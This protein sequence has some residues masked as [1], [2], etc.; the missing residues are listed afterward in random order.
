MEDSTWDPSGYPITFI[1]SADRIPLLADALARA[2]RVAVDTE[3]HSA[4]TFDDGLWSA[5]R[6]VA[7]ALKHTDGSYEAF[8]VDVRDVPTSALA[9]VLGKIE[10]ADAWNANFDDRVLELAGC[11]ITSWRDAMFTDGLLHSGAA[12]FEFWHGLAF[13]AKKYLGIELAG[14]GTTQTSYDGESDLSEEQVRYPGCDALVTLRVAEIL[15]ERVAKHGLA[16][17]VALEQ[18]ARPFILEM[19]KRGLPFDMEGWRREVLEEH[20][21]GKADALRQLADLTGGSEI[22]LFGES[23]T[24]SWNPDSDPQAREALNKWAAAAVKEFTGGQLL[25]KTDKL[26]KIVLKQIKHPVA[27]ELLRYRNHSKVLSTYGENLDTFIGA[28]NRIRP[29]YKQGGVVATG[30]LASD[31]PNAQNFS[32]L[33][34]PYFRPLVEVLPDGTEIPRC[35]VY[36]DLSQAELRVL[37]E[38]AGEERMREQF[39]LGGDFHARTAGEM[40]NV[41]MDELKD[42]DPATYGNNRKKAKGVSFGIPYGLGAE[43]LAT[44]LTVA[45]KLETSK[46]EAQEMLKRYAQAFPAVDAWLTA[47]DRFVKE[48]AKNSTGV[49]WELSFHLYEL[50]SA[51]APV[52]KSLKRR[53]GR[54]ASVEEISYEVMPDARLEK[55]LENKLGHE[56]N[57]EEVEAARAAH[58]SDVTW[59]L[60]FDAPVVLRSGGAPWFFESRSLTGRRRLFTVPMDSSPSMKGK[61]EGVIT[62]AVLTVCTSDQERVAALRAEFADATSLDL[63]VGVNRL[64]RRA[65]EKDFQYRNRSWQHRKSER[66]AC[67]KTF[68]GKN[69][70]RKY[71]LL[72]F[73]REHMGAEVVESHLLPMAFE[74]QV[75]SMGNRFRNH[76]IQSLVADVGLQYY[77]DLHARL[78]R[79]RNAFPVQAVHDSI[80]IECDLAEAEELCRE[81]QEALQ[82][83]LA[84]WCPNVPAVADADIRLSLADEDVV[85]FKDIPGLLA[86]LASQA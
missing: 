31:R 6:I 60:G 65:G 61:F 26:D 19:T 9:P 37:A 8:V 34:K 52:A 7:V 23:D 46:E 32:P 14:K 85:S 3:T 49:D 30:R 15:D 69:K 76:P 18:A 21:H 25:E 55:E 39:R 79:Y 86:K 70:R 20:E 62:S 73:V 35:F 53:L 29:R 28:D 16:V 2:E 17:P 36:A 54:P 75:R 5:L 4:T 45:S 42:S 40:F 10:N 58:I 11:P 24:P 77:A 64:P 83:A 78:K 57:T 50:H 68:E 22:T 47:R 44:N 72:K 51:A 81:V 13:A 1:V 48:T 41:N 66:M 74:D 71:E 12:G 38:I 63:P 27:Q 59:A 67:I 43:A 84:Q 80:S 56:P 82:S 33:M